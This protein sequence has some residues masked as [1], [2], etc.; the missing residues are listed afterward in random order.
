MVKNVTGGNRAKSFARKGQSSGGRAERL[1][2]PTCELEQYACVTKMFGN[3]MC[4]IYLNDNTRLIGHIR[5]K[6]TGSKKRNNLITQFSIVM[7]GLREW[8]NP[9]KNCDILCTVDDNEIEQLK[10]F[11]QINIKHIIQMKLSNEAHGTKEKHS[12]DSIVFTHDIDSD[13]PEIAP[14][15][16][17]EKFDL[18]MIDEVDIEDI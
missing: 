5:N 3:G 9:M 13:M 15:P 12:G 2:L 18:G 4:E 8:E 10:Q 16:N 7:V 6:F 14:Q 11:P 17:A 1:R